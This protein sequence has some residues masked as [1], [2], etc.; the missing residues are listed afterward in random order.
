MTQ[1]PNA[2]EISLAQRVAARTASKW[3]GIDPEDL[4]SHLYLWLCQ[5]TKHLVGWR[6][7]EGDG[8]LYVSLRREAAKYCAAEQA[9][10]VGRPIGDDNFY[11]PELLERSLPFVFEGV[12]QHTVAVSPLTDHAVGRVEAASEAQT[13]LLDIRQA[14]NGMSHE[15]KEILAWRFYDGLTFSEIGELRNLTKDGAKKAVDRA[16]KRLSDALAGDLPFS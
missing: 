5:N 4:T 16:V 9:A 12:P 14:Y 15:T 7:D 8:R 6:G 11:T 3:K 1:A 13:I 2:E 10:R